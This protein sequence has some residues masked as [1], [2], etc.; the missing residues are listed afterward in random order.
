QLLRAGTRYEDKK[1][2]EA[3]LLEARGKLDEIETNLREAVVRAPAR[4]FI[5][6]LAVRKG[7]LVPPNQ[8][9]L[10]VLRADDLWVKAY[11]PETE[12]GKVRPDAEVDVTIDAYPGRQFR[13]SI[14]HISAASEFTPRNV[15][16][17]E[18]RRYQVF[19]I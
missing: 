18:E 12:L 13:A 14:M 19:G 1:S 15:Q 9:V 5:E 16:S 11:V 6:V 3:R 8:P 2:A 4:V 17:A 10:R 7:D